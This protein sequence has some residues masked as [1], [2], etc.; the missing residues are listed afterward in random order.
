MVSDRLAI[1]EVGYSAC[2]REVNTGITGDYYGREL[3][4]RVSSPSA[5]GPAILGLLT[6]AYSTPPGESPHD[7]IVYRQLGVIECRAV[8]LA[9][10][11]HSWHNLSVESGSEIS[12][13]AGVRRGAF[14]EALSSMLSQK[15]FW[16]ANGP[17]FIPDFSASM[18]A[19]EDGLVRCRVYGALMALYWFVVGLPPEPVSPWLCLALLLGP[20]ALGM[21]DANSIESLDPEAIPQLRT[22]L[23][24]RAEDDL[25]TLPPTHPLQSWLIEVMDLQVR[26]TY[27]PHP[28]VYLFPAAQPHP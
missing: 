21:L 26:S 15:S 19:P 28:R 22:W 13:G 9:G 10:F 7:S 18:Y 27:S 6:V 23:D 8:P 2:M 3:L 17:Y 1:S 25:S 11:L 12:S 16:K 14:T 4:L 5:F 20:S 24:I